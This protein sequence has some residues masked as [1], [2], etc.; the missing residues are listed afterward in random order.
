[1]N[2]TGLGKVSRE[3]LQT[4]EPELA[5]IVERVAAW[6]PLTVAVGHRN[7]EAQ[8]EAFRTGKSQLRWPHSRH[9]R[10]PSQAV[11]LAPL[12][13]SAEKGVFID[14]NDRESFTLLAGAMMAT[15]RALGV[16]VRW[17]G[18]WN[19]NYVTKDERFRDYPHFELVDENAQGGEG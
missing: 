5:A 7:E 14:W 18:D 13:W 4:V 3:R 15:A 8:N 11:D 19:Q 17:G 16:R 6:F 12:Q 10:F 2:L 9:N 1:M